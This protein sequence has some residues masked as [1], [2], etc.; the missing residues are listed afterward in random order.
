MKIEAK[1]AFQYLNQ[2]KALAILADAHE[3]EGHA[4]YAK[5]L[6]LENQAHTIRTRECNEGNYSNEKEI[7]RITNR[8]KTLLPRIHTFFCNGDPRGYA[9]KIKEHEAQTLRDKGI[10]IHTDMGGYGILAPEF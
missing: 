4:I 10:P 9:L 6:K 1:N 5:L 8:V 7:T 2:C 3:F